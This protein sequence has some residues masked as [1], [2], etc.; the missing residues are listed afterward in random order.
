MGPGLPSCVCMDV[1][2]FNSNTDYDAQ[3]N[4]ITPY[5]KPG[6]EADS[7]QM[8]QRVLDFLETG[9]VKIGSGATLEFGADSICVHGDNPS[10]VNNIK[11]LRDKLET[12][13][14]EIRAI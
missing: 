3:G 12:A 9:K 11:A 7:E 8:A 2:E 10:A 1:R 5:Y 14:Y 13:G 6:E 4:V